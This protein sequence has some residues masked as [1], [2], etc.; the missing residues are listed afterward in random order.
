MVSQGTLIPK[1]SGRN[2]GGRQSLERSPSTLEITSDPIYHHFLFLFFFSLLLL[3]LQCSAV[4]YVCF[5]SHV[6]LFSFDDQ[7]DFNKPCFVGNDSF[8]PRVPSRYLNV[9]TDHGAEKGTS[10]PFFFEFCLTVCIMIC[11]F[12][13]GRGVRHV[14]DLVLM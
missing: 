10:C 6:S 13:G 9:G 2:T 7:A 11:H 5:H 1:L 8:L 3:L 12:W 14:G 4:L